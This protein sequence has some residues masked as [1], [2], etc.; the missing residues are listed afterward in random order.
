MRRKTTRSFFVVFLCVLLLGCQGAPAPKGTVGLL[1]DP[2]KRPVTE[3]SPVPGET[4]LLP[5]KEEQAPFSMKGVWLSQFDL[6]GVYLSGSSQRERED[7]T[8]RMEG[9]LTSVKEMGFDT[10][11][12]QVHPYGDSFYP[13]EFFPP[14]RYVTGAYG[15]AFAYDPFAI[16]DSLCEKLSLR[17]HAWINPGRALT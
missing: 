4:G 6:S 13:S 9:I 10:V 17:L 11:V 8:L 1:P 7:F 5:P 14:S 12:V 3:E 15:R 2:P 16:V